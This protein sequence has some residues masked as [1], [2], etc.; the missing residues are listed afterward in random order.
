MYEFSAYSDGFSDYND[1]HHVL[2]TSNHVISRIGY[3]CM[4]TPF[5]MEH[6]P[7]DSSMMELEWNFETSSRMGIETIMGFFLLA[8]LK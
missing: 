3:F 2:C 1:T 4:K 6:F 5:E 8:T 7:F